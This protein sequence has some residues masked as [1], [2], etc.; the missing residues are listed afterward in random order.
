DGGS[1]QRESE[2]ETFHANLRCATTS[3]SMLGPSGARDPNRGRRSVSAPAKRKCWSVVEEGAAG[4]IAP[5]LVTGQPA[6]THNGAELRPARRV[7]NK[8]LSTETPYR[9][10]STWSS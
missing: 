9:A 3:E 7:M 5:M 10:A 8:T 1:H 6:S 2:N 4:V